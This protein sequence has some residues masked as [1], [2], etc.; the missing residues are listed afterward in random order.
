MGRDKVF[1]LGELGIALEKSEPKIALM[2]LTTTAYKVGG[3][4]GFDSQKVRY[5]DACSELIK[6]LGSGD[7]LIDWH[8]AQ[9][10]RSANQHIYTGIYFERAADAY[11]RA[12]GI[13]W[14]RQEPSE[15]NWTGVFSLLRDAVLAYQ[16]GGDSEAASRCYYRAMTLRRQNLEGFSKMIMWVTW[17]VWGWGESGSK[18]GGSH[19]ALCSRVLGS[20]YQG[21]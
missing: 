9:Y 21:H 8:Y 2:L 4:M 1:K 3:L 6:R 15:R 12:E 19:L 5:Y 7:Y 10:L 18:W 20:W 16:A 11:S 13:I 14:L 17:L